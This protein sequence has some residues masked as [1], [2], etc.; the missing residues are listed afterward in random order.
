LL[1]RVFKRTLAKAGL[2]SATRFHDLRHTCATLLLLRGID[3]NTV[4][5]LLGYANI[6]ITLG[7]YGHVLP[8]MRDRVAEMM[9]TI[10]APS[11]T[12]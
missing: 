4:K 10:L 9:D 5:D 7:V 3:P 6:S 1:N 2:P 8:N 12:A 11:A